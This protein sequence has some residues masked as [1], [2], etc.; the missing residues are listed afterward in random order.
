MITDT[1][2]P[3]SDLVM[4]LESVRPSTLPVGRA[5]AVFC[6]GTCFH[7]LEAIKELAILVDG[8]RHPPGAFAMPRPDLLYP[9]GQGPMPERASATRRDGYGQ[10]TP[11]AHS[12]C[13]GFWATIPVQS[14]ASPGAVE[15]QLAVRT[16]SG[17]EL[18]SHLG[19]I[20]V[21]D[22]EPPT[23]L[24]PV[25]D[26]PGDGLIAICMATFEPDIRLF[27]TQIA[28]LRSQTDR[29]W[30]CLISD[31]CSRPERFE[32]I[33]QIV[34][35]DRRFVV[36]RSE[37]QLGFYS[38][39]ERALTM[40]PPEATLVALCDQDDYWQPEKLEVL[41]GAL[42]DAQLVYSDVRLVDA[43][44]RVLRD[45][46]YKGRRNNWTN[47]ASQLVANT[48]TG[49]AMLFPR[50]LMQV[51]LPFPQGPGFLFH[52]HWLGAVAIA[53]G[54]VTFVDRPLHDY[55][56]HA[57]AVFGDVSSGARRSLTAAGAGPRRP[58]SWKPWRG[59]FE[60]WRAAY[61]YGYLARE[62]Q[63]QTLIIRCSNTLSPRKRGVLR[64][65]LASARS[66]LA[67]TWLAARP[68]RAM[69]G[70]NETLGSEADLAR[71]IL[72]RWLITIRVRGAK[73][74][75]GKT[76]DSRLPDPAAFEQKRL[77]RWRARL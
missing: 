76:H 57:G 7:R 23:S 20:D 41:R 37:E 9:H 55:V 35:A 51:A 31:D 56:Q 74:T 40:V 64:R 6:L 72:W 66:P 12:Y 53:T 54:K 42:G 30:I 50:E 25:D 49:A 48:M 67:F 2:D 24:G 26:R 47:L 45:T 18:I 16:A 44:G 4:N 46:L 32:Q 8:V 1:G 5:A 68:L 36:S 71:G 75:A 43:E 34:G 3:T 14:R 33:E 52:D 29:R 21:L 63:A 39:F 58:L 61:F 73:A 22:P 15:L 60:R 59:C 65:F 69:L 70:F 10:G 28:S 27:R 19:R 38:N 13:S 17:A 77:R 11:N 62:V